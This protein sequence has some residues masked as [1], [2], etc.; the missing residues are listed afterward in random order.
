LWNEP[1]NENTGSYAT[2]ELSDKLKFVEALLARVFSW[3][4]SARPSQPLTSGLWVGDWSSPNNLTP[5]HRIQVEQSDILSFHNYASPQEFEQRVTWLQQYQRPLLCTEFMARSVGS[6]FENIL[7]LAKRHKV[8]AINWGFAQGKCQTHLPW[9]SWQTPYDSCQPSV[10]FHEILHTD[11][12]AYQE[13]EV[14]FIRQIAFRLQARA[15][16]IG[17]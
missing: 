5:I 14:Q 11:G 13:S 8:A 6:T 10:W 7:P 9:D 15:A 1:D 3:A 2:L 17:K 12:S 16:K 4:R